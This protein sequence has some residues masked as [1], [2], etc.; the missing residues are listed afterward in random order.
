MPVEIKG[1]EYSTIPEMSAAMAEFIRNRTFTTQQEIH[2]Q[3]GCKYF[4]PI[5]KAGQETGEMKC[6]AKSGKAC[7]AAQETM[8]TMIG[9]HLDPAVYEKRAKKLYR[10]IPVSILQEIHDVAEDI[11]TKTFAR[12]A[13]NC[14]GCEF[15]EGD[16]SGAA[17]CM[18]PAPTWCPKAESLITS[19]FRRARGAYDGI[20]V[21]PQ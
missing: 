19:Q 16:D 9:N 10:E 11:R 8:A 4:K 12:H 5:M 3:A 21:G 20:E 18:A 13:W 17:R 1:R 7:P 6:A 2:C 15:L 14:R